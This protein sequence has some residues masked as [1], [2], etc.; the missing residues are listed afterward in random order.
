M[1]MTENSYTKKTC[2]L[3]QGAICDGA[4]TLCKMDK[5][6]Q[7]PTGIC[8]ASISVQYEH[9]HTILYNLYYIF[10]SLDVG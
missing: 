9:L 4:F 7:N 5:L 10:I 8:V 2:S 3:Q 1:S 6:A